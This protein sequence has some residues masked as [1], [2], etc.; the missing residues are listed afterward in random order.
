MNMF[1]SVRNSVT[2]RDT[3]PGIADNGMTKLRL[4]AITMVIVG[5]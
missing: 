4:A 3:L 2:I 1:V 5:K